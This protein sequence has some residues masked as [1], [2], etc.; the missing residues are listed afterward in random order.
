[1]ELK[2]L[3]IELCSLMS[4]TGWETRE[5]K[6]V[7]ELLGGGFDESYTDSVGNIVFIRRSAKENAPK[8]LIDAHMDEIGLVVTDIKE[9]GF[10]SVANIGG[11]DTRILQAS[12]VVIYGKKTIRGVVASTPPHLQKP[13][14]SKK[15]AEIG[16]ILIDTGYPKEELEEFVRVGT[17]IGF[18]PK[19]TELLGD[20]LSGKGFDDKACAA[21]AAYGISQLEKERLAGDVYL[22]LSAHEET[23][24]YGGIAAAAYA[25]DPDY[26][27]VIDVNHAKTPGTEKRDTIAYRGGPS[28]TVTSVTDRR[29]TAMTRELAQQKEIAH[30]IS[31]SASHTGTNAPELQLTRAG[32]PTVDVGL[33]LGS[34]HTC[35]EVLC[36]EDCT[37]LARLVGEFCASSEIAEVFGK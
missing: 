17:P 9:G 29:L 19:Y 23:G 10:L 13:G 18:L 6:K 31:V 4:V 26:A 24:R 8:I 35:C 21:C 12:D 16:D 1:M 30:Q 28:V 22:V 3:I 7:R 32:I 20:V 14:E 37:T 5:E 2:E 34:M 27:M 25:I 33:P 15:L 36:I 11:V